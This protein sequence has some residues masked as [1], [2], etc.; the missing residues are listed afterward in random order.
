MKRVFCK[1]CIECYCLKI[2]I[3]FLINMSLCAI[4]KQSIIL[5]KQTLRIPRLFLKSDLSNQVIGLLFLIVSSN[6]VAE[7]LRVGIPIPGQIPF[8]WRDGA[9][10]Y[11]G[12][13]P[14]TLRMMATDLSLT[15]EFIPLSQARLRRHFEI[16]KID[17]EMGVSNKIDDPE[18]LQ[19][20]SL[21]TRPF[22]IVNEV[23]IYR[24]ELSFPVFIL[25]DL[26]GQRVATVRGNTVP[27]NLIREDFTNEWQIA[28]RVHR[29]W[30]DIGLMKEAVALHYQREEKLNYQTSLPYASNPVSF[31]LHTHKKMLLEP[32]NSSIQRLEKEGALENLVCK[33]LC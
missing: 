13:Y 17:I 28:Q 30:N 23:I 2:N 1:V 8:F 14:D 33:Y 16:G 19:R 24:P 4:F 7:T 26:A 15:L 29:G 18:K 32:M 9:G 11:Q 10:L 3:E 27:D 31:R 5:K 21:F 25:K 20:V 6:T 12:I 22:I